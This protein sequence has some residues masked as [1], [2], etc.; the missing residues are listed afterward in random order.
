VI[1][2]RHDP[3][4]PP[5]DGRALAEAIAGAR[6]LELEAAHLSN[7]EAAPQFTAELLAFLTA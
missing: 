3:A 4:T 7:I 1:A 5:A 6:Y 2:G